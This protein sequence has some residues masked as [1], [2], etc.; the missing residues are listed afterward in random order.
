MN[1]QRSVPYLERRRFGKM[2]KEGKLQDTLKELKQLAETWKKMTN[3][4]KSILASYASVKRESTDSID[5]VIEKEKEMMN[6]FQRD[7]KQIEEYIEK[8]K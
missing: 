8:H 2:A 6:T 7:I 4:H 3:K 5:A 1:R